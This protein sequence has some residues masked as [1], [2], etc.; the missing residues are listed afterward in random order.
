VGTFRYRIEGSLREAVTG[1]PLPG[2]LI[3]AYDLDLL[4]DDSLGDAVSDA[5]G[6]F[7]IHFTERAFAEIPGQRPDIYLRVFDAAGGVELANTR[8]EVRH[9][10]RAEEHFDLR[11]ATPRGSAAAPGR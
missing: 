4:K 5:E 8:H 2:L 9:R 6:R 1:D 10:A 7:Q 3:R 11:V